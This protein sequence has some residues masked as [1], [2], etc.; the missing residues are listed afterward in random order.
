MHRDG[1]FD[2][3]D[4]ERQ[5]GVFVSHHGGREVAPEERDRPT[6]DLDEDPWTDDGVPGTTDDLP[7]DHGVDL[8]TPADHLILSPERR[9]SG[10]GDM[11]ETG[12]D[13]REQEPPLGAVDE[14][15]LW[16]RQRGLID[17]S[18]D[19]AA[20]YAGLTDA[21]IPRVEA[22]VGEDAA[23]VLPDSPEG[24]SATGS[25]NEPSRGG[26]RRR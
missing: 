19:E 3:E 16:H 15:D 13:D 8:S 20:R 10:F 14:R 24:E 18:G 26:F 22:A 7:Y 25:G 12:V 5:G 1:S 21:D 2:D 11:G 23:E 17:E 4:L 9:N 6:D